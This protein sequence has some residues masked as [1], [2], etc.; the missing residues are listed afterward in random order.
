MF[1]ERSARRIAEM[2]ADED[3]VDRLKLLN[4]YHTIDSHNIDWIREELSSIDAKKCL[5][6]LE[7][8]FSR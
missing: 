7:E 4:Q 1:I 5:A 6:F 2:I 8:Q 3:A